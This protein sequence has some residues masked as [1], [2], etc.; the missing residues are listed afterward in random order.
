MIS[1]IGLNQDQNRTPFQTIEFSDFSVS[2]LSNCSDFVDEVLNHAHIPW[3][4]VTV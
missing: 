3:K 1:F 4:Q 2:L